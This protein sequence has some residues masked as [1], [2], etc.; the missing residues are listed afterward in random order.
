MGYVSFVFLEGFESGVVSIEG[1]AVV[2]KEQPKC[3][4]SEADHLFGIVDGLWPE[5]LLA[6]KVADCG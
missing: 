3:L 2:A 4:E 1:N 5:V 6:G